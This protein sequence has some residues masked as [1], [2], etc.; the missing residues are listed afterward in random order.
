MSA[1]SDDDLTEQVSQ[2]QKT[3]SQKSQS[4]K[5]DPPDSPP[6]TEPKDDGDT[7]DTSQQGYNLNDNQQEHQDK[8]GG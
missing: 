5:E 3:A 7:C 4:K 1:V 6:H 2:G 8:H